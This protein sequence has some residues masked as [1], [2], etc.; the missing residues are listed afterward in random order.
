MEKQ[1]DLS[2]VKKQSTFKLVIPIEVERKIRYLCQKIPNVEWSGTLF[3]THKGSM[4]EGNLVITCKDI[5]VMDIGSQAYTEFDMSPDVI[6]YMCDNTEL[7]DMQMGLIHSHNNMAAFFS[8]TDTNTLK[9]EG[10]DRNHFVSLIV[11]NEGTYTAAITRKVKSVKT[12][13]ESYSYGSFND[14][15]VSSAKEYTEESEVIE[16]YGLDITKEGVYYSFQE[17]DKRLDEIRK[18]KANA[19]PTKIVTPISVTYPRGREINAGGRPVYTP[20]LFKE[21]ED[22][23]AKYKPA[24]ETDGAV[25]FELP[26]ISQKDVQHVLIQ[27]LT[28]SNIIRDTSKIDLKKWV[29]TMPQLFGERFGVDEAGLKDF[30]RWADQHCEFLIFDKEPPFIEAEP[31]IDW[32]SAFAMALYE[33]LDALPKNDYIEIFKS[34]VEQWITQ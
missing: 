15:E 20:S 5:F 31:E 4:E 33:E 26:D 28:G 22:E 32:V 1:K 2:L 14:E 25:P 29:A 19:T 16:Y 24:K 18:K 9:E 34:T 23:V 17:L 30:E 6:S 7:L 27:M 8:G 10:R 11:N 21:M 12:I 13:N 3:Y